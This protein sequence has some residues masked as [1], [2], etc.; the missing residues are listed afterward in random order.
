MPGITVHPGETYLVSLEQVEVLHQGQGRKAFLADLASQILDRLYALPPS[1]FPEVIAALAEAGKRRQIQVLFDDP[2]TQAAVNEFGWGGPFTFPGSVDRLAIM[3]ANVAPVSKLNVLLTMDHALDVTLAAD[4][5]AAERLVTTYTN[6]FGPKLAPELE[7]VRSAFFAGNLGSYNR[8][9]LVPGANVTSV[10]SDDPEDPVTDP[11]SVEPEG[12][13]LAIGNYQLIRPG[14]VH[15]TTEYNAPH[16][17]AAAA[18]GY[19]AGGT[20]RLMFR[21]EPGRDK[22]SLVV[23]V[24]VPTGMAPTEWS[25]GRGPGGTDGD[26]HGHDRVRPRFRGRVRPALTAVT[27]RSR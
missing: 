11:G 14:T 17:V 18:G 21:K 23:R 7:R 15:L 22:D 6:H 4:G 13:S 25:Q 12:D 19:S 2:A 26:V 3:E 27:S 8:R 5:S 10:S 1:R 9:Y 24:T 20:Y 16:V